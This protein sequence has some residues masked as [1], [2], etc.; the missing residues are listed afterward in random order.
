MTGEHRIVVLGAGYAGLAAARQAA[1]AKGVRVTVIDARAELVE[2]VRLHQVLAGQ[3]VPRWNLRELLEPKGIEFTQARA[4]RI[5]PEA[6]RVELADAE[7][8]PYDSLVY[9]LGSVADTG[10]VPGLAAH[11]HAVATPEDVRRAPELSGR[12]AVVGGGSTGI[13][14]ATELAESR[15]D[16]EVLLISADEPGAWLSAKARGHIGAVLDRLGVRVH[17]GAKVAAVTPTGLDLVDGA[18]VPAGTVLWTAGFAVPDVAARSG[19]AVDARGRVLVGDDLRAVAHPDIYA[20]GDAAVVAG[21][22]EREL[23]MA[24]ATALPAGKYAATA[25]TARLRGKEPAARQFRYY[26]Q[27]LSLGRR[28]AVIQ[29]LNPDDT[30]TARAVTG[31]PAVWF[32]EGIVRGAGWAARP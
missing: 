19:L 15:P 23:R 3:E 28:D 10:G 25:I 4:T 6:K 27:C 1:R 18:H 29:F 30:P 5:D 17:A 9:A 21:P 13:E 22:G 16:L 32:K 11:A 8:V 20:V 12:V 2:R 31:R 14:V 7:P 24:C 26:F